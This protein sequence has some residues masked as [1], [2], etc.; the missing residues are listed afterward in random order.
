MAR[1]RD[2]KTMSYLFPDPEE[3]SVSIMH[4]FEAQ[5]TE[6]PVTPQTV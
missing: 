5:S 4:D 1:R 6:G 3:K 2:A